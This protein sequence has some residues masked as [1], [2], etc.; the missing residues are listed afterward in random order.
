MPRFGRQS[1]IKLGEVHT[2][3]MAL[4]HAVVA[5][6]DCTVLCGYRGEKEQNEAYLAGHSRARFGES[7]HNFKP[8]LA[9]DMVPFPID[10]SNEQRFKDFVA[11]VKR[12]ATEMGI[13]ITCGADFK[14]FK[15]YPHFELKEWKKMAGIK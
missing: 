15:D 2:D 5:E 10:W 11:V 3:L 9:I 14:T 1:L 12:K 8:A 13:E 6:V 7:P 4:A